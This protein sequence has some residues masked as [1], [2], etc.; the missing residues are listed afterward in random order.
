MVENIV[1]DVDLGDEEVGVSDFDEE[2]EVS[3]DEDDVE[4]D[5]DDG[6]KKK[7]FV[8]K[9]EC[10]CCGVCKLCGFLIMCCYKI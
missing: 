10:C 1:I 5:V 2:F 9:V 3:V 6:K 8:V 7:K 4:I